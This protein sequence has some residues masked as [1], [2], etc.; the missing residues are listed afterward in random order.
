MNNQ[1]AIKILKMQ[2][3]EMGLPNQGS[4]WKANADTIALDLAITALEAQ[5]DDMWIPISSGV[6][7][8]DRGYPPVICCNTE[9]KWTDAA[10][11]SSHGHF[12]NCEGIIIRPTHGKPL[13]EPRKEVHP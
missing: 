12:I 8:E 11:V 1:E 10:F 6:L 3:Y 13:P 5:K 4:T 9:D 7:P 2:R